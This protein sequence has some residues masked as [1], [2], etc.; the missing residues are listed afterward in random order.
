MKY[1]L[2]LSIFFSS[3]SFQ[4]AKETLGFAPAVE[5]KPAWIKKDVKFVMQNSDVQVADQQKDVRDYCQ[6]LE[7]SFERYGWGKSECDKVKWSWQLHSHDG[8]PL[9]Y[10][11][12]ADNNPNPEKPI[13]T[14]L[15]MCG[16]HGDEITPIKFCFDVI[17]MLRDIDKSKPE[18]RENFRN[19]RV[20]V[21]PLVSP[22]S[23]FKRYP[24]RTN[25]RGVDINRNFPTK[26]WTKD[27]LRLW[28]HRYGKDKRR[29]PGAKAGS[30]TE[31]QF[32]VE[33][34]DNFTPGKIVSVHS[35]LTMLDYDGP[36]DF[37]T[38]GE[39]G[40]KASQLLIQM[41]R[42]ASGYRIKNYPFFPGSLGNY[43]GNERGI[44]TFTLELP[45]SDNR[46]HK[47]YWKQFKGA[48]RA[49]IIQELSVDYGVAGEANTS[50]EEHLN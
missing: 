27:A 31:T 38:G 28:A 16:V 29:Y 45:S 17:S 30:E 20:V 47:E 42:K 12:W 13:T 35:P 33:L 50:D 10:A 11:I 22:D 37:Q 40:N 9:I 44:P 1:L 2:L 15:I 46:R 19:K 48:I 8:D 26:D 49:A 32:Q 41:S 6:K 7:Q 39:V 5:Q 36:E 23:Y 4:K 34:I 24:S 18:F 25:A 14:T 21:A 43:A 3:C